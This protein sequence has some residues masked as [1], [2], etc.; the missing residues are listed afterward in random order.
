[1][2][3]LALESPVTLVGVDTVALRI[4]LFILFCNGA[5]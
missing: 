3:V 4:G 1:M 5:Y 2:V